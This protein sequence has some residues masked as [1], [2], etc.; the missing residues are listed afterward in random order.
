MAYRPPNV[1]V[2]HRSLCVFS[3]T[4]ALP[5]AVVF[6][7][8]AVCVSSLR[9]PETHEGTVVSGFEACVVATRTKLLE[10]AASHHKD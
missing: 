3:F 9:S 10:V 4:V 5:C 7:V 8:E 6:S 1:Y 2:A